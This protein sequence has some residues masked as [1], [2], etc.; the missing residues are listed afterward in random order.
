MNSK[1][2]ISKFPEN[3]INLLGGKDNFL[4]LPVTSGNDVYNSVSLSIINNCPAFIL[5]VKFNNES[6]V[7]VFKQKNINNLEI[8]QCSSL[9]PLFSH[10]EFNIYNPNKNQEIEINNI[11][12]LIN[13][14]NNI[15]ILNYMNGISNYD[16]YIDC[17]AELY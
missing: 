11:K 1:D 2:L 6:Y 16:I 8:W 13:R 3:I 10:N 5:S 4:N 7:E 12:E 15:K 9:S 17:F 14:T